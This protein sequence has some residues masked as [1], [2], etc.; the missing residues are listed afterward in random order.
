MPKK[1]VLV[2]LPRHQKSG[3]RDEKIKKKIFF[4]GV[5]EDL[6]GSQ[7]PEKVS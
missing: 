1:T 3:V 2:L 6:R 7:R 5:L 4:W